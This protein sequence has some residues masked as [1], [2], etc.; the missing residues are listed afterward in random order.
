MTKPR[1]NSIKEEENLI[2]RILARKWSAKEPILIFQNFAE[3][4]AARS[5]FVEI[6][7]KKGR[8]TESV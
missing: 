5:A 3:K 1:V 2:L 7:A 8:L 4:T 6:G